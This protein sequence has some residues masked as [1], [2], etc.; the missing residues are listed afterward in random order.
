M[1]NKI[2]GKKF[3]KDIDTGRVSIFVNLTA[4]VSVSAM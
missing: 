2:I 3:G 4:P 1:S